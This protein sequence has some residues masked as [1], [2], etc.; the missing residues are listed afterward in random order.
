[1]AVE[2]LSSLR[3]HICL[4]VGGYLINF[5]NVLLVALPTAK[6]T[7]YPTNKRRESHTEGV[8]WLSLRNGGRRCAGLTL[9]LGVVELVWRISRLGC[10]HRGVG[11]EAPPSGWAGVREQRCYRA[12]S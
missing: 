3:L 11:F 2:P 4:G 8:A 7:S 6:T 9:R 1:M 12:H 5:L 10:P